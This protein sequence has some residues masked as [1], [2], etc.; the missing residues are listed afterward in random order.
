M[1]QKLTAAPQQFAPL[2]D[3]GMGVSGNLFTYS[4]SP[5]SEAGYS[6]H[7]SFWTFKMVA[8]E[9]LRHIKFDISALTN[10]IFY[11]G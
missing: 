8:L 9:L 10:A 7:V 5:A 2:V 3:A 6:L 1:Y 11:D 4:C